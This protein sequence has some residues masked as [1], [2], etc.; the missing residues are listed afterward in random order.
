MTDTKKITLKTAGAGYV[1]LIV[2][3]LASDV[4]ITFPGTTGTLGVTASGPLV[5]RDTSNDANATITATNDRVLAFTAL[6]TARTVAL[7]AATSAG[8]TITIID[9][10]GSCSATN[11]ITIN[12]ASSDTIDGQT[13]VVIGTPYGALVLV[14]D[15]SN[16]WTIRKPKIR[17]QTFTADGSWVAPAGV[18]WVHLT[19][20]GGGGGGGGATTTAAAG[21]GGSGQNI[22]G[23]YAVVPGTS[24]SVTIGTAGAGGAAAYGFGGPGGSTSFG[25]VVTAIGGGYANGGYTSSPV[26][27]YFFLCGVGGYG[28]GSFIMATGHSSA[29]SSSPYG[30]GGVP[31][32]DGTGYAGTKGGNTIWAG[33]GAGGTTANTKPG[34]G[35][36]AGGYGTG[37]AGGNGSTTGTA[38]T[39]A[40]ANTGAGGGGG[41]AGSSQSAGGNGGTGICIVSWME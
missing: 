27:T 32:L 36:G 34:G 4:D 11:T 12:R 18:Y 21:G 3:Q 9:E 15:G 23:W 24:Y 19:M 2:P 33:G 16:K 7:P 37:G 26:G 8:Q 39:A 22:I 13:S 38:G 17:R 28:T 20:C 14:A 31:G 35:G 40:A 29:T 6:S 5:T 10:S 41:G 1:N 30:Q 25:T